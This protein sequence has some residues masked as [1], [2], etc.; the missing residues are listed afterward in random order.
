VDYVK[1]G[2]LSFEDFLDSKDLWE[3]ALRRSLDN[4]IFQTWEWL[5]TWWRHYG[6]KRRSFLIV[7]TEGKKILAAAPLMYTTYNLLG[8][9]IRKMEC[10][11]DPAADYHTF[12]LTKERPECVRLIMNYAERE[13]ADWD[14][15]ELSEIPQN[16]ETAR[17]L[18]FL[19]PKFNFKWRVQN[20]CPYVTLPI[21]FEDY[22]QRLGFN[23]RRNLR[24][25]ERRAQK[26]YK[27][28]FRIC[29]DKEEIK[30][31]M[32]TFFVLHQKRWQSKGQTGA[33]SDRKFRDFHLD[34]AACFA[35]RGWLA[36]NFVTLN[37]APATA[38]YAFVYGRK[39]YSYLSG[40]DPQFS[41]YRIGSLRLMYLIRHCII[42]GLTEYD[43][44]RG[45]E[46][47][48][49]QWNTSIRN[50]FEFWVTRRRIVPALYDIITKNDRI[51]TLARMLGKRVSLSQTT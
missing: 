15:I 40:F 3:D 13:A 21:K 32:E 27:V 26:D 5:S 14:F 33:F 19:G 45:D 29:S 22:F 20:R 37:E 6:D 43:F 11:A 30:R 34:I 10:L 17:L 46:P 38:G 18:A 23:L 39:L 24:K 41:K 12:L 16:S 31:D 44:M 42:N 48:K 8:L 9:R 51:S 7:V 4:H 47:Y 1:I 49:E 28:D 35:E 2:E 25:Y 50:N 36:L